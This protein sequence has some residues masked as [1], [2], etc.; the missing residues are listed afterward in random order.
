MTSTCTTKSPD[1][2]LCSLKRKQRRS[3]LIHLREF[4]GNFWP[5]CGAKKGATCPRHTSLCFWCGRHWSEHITEW[6]SSEGTEQSVPL[7]SYPGWKFLRE[8]QIK[9][10]VSSEIVDLTNQDI[11]IKKC[12]LQGFQPDP[13]DPKYE[14][15]KA[16]QRKQAFE[17]LD[18]SLRRTYPA[19]S[20]SPLGFLEE[21]KF[22]NYPEPKIGQEEQD[23]VGC[24]RRKGGHESTHQAQDEVLFY[25][26]PD[27]PHYWMFPS[28][29]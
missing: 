20:K 23:H 1:R 8:S 26:R 19:S 4:G 2:R 21:A 12:A 3:P 27:L 5:S 29:S 13:E 6:N 10:I 22:R 25:W 9:A 15:I 11:L 7:V 14:E 28:H 18:D 17:H 16:E 24:T